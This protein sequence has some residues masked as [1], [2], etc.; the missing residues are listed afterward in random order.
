M[1]KYNVM[2]TRTIELSTEVEVSAKDEDTAESKALELMDK[3]ILSWQ[4][5]GQYDWEECSDDC[6]VDRVEEV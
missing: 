2:I 3:A 4:I 6:V 5:T 1:P